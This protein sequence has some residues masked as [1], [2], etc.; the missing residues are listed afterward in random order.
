MKQN[1]NTLHV[2]KSPVIRPV[3][4]PADWWITHPHS[5]QVNKEVTER[6]RRASLNYMPCSTVV[7]FVFVSQQSAGGDM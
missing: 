7:S 4:E 1:A 5:P 6:A 3:R 2:H